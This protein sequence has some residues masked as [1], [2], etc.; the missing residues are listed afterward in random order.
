MRKIN[1]LLLFFDYFIKLIISNLLDKNLFIL[2]NNDNRCSQ[3]SCDGSL[4]HPFENLIQTYTYIQ[5]NIDPNLYNINILIMSNTTTINN[6][7]LSTYLS[8]NSNGIYNIVFSHQKVSILSNFTSSTIVI[9][10]ETNLLAI[11]YINMLVFHNININFNNNQFRQVFFPFISLI[12]NNIFIISNSSLEFSYNLETYYDSFIGNQY[13]MT[14]SLN[15][16]TFNIIDCVFNQNLFQT[17]ILNI[18]SK[19]SSFFIKR[20]IFTNISNY[21]NFYGFNFLGSFNKISIN[22]SKIMNSSQLFYI[23]NSSV[24]LVIFVNITTNVKSL[25]NPS[26]LIYLNYFN[27]ITIEN[28]VLLD[29]SMNSFILINLNFNNSLILNSSQFKNS[30]FQNISSIIHANTSNFINIF[31]IIIENL[32]V[33]SSS[34]IRLEC[35]NLLYMQ[36]TSFLSCSLYSVYGLIYLNNSNIL[37]DNCHFNKILYDNNS[38]IG[39]FFIYGSD[40]ANITNSIFANGN[41]QGIGGIIFANLIKIVYIFNV[42]CYNQT[43]GSAVLFYF[44]SDC[45]VII[46]HLHVNI[47]F[48]SFDLLN[49][50]GNIVLSNSNNFSIKNSE[51][52][53]STSFGFGTILACSDS[54]RINL[55]NLTLYDTKTT[56]IGIIFISSNNIF[57]SE[58]IKII[59]VQGNEMIGLLFLENNAI[60]VYNST[61]FDFTGETEKG[62]VF[63]LI[64][65]NTFHI[66][67]CFLYNIVSFSGSGI[68]LQNTNIMHI[69]NV[70]FD[71]HYNLNKAFYGG[72]L[73]IRTNNTLFINISKFLSSIAPNGA[74]AISIDFN[75]TIYINTCLFYN[76]SQINNTHGQGTIIYLYH[77]NNI[78]I[79]NSSFMSSSGYYGGGV[80]CTIYNIITINSSIFY[81]LTTHNQSSALGGW[82]I[83]KFYVENSSFID[84]TCTYSGGVFY[85][86]VN[87]EGIF[88]NIVCINDFSWNFGGVFAINIL[89]KILIKNSYFSNNTSYSSGGL[90]YIDTN[91]NIFLRNIT[92]IGCISNLF[93]S[94]AFLS[95]GNM[96]YVIDSHIIN[97]SIFLDGGAFY[98]LQTNNFT[99]INTEII[100]LYNINNEAVNGGVFY[101]DTENTLI[102]SNNKIF[103]VSGVISGGIFYLN[104]LNHLICQTS[105]FVKI[106]IYFGGI[107]LYLSENNT[108]EINNIYGNYMNSTNFGSIYLSEN[109]V[110]Y[111]NNSKFINITTK[112]YD[113]GLFYLK[114][115]NIIKFSTSFLLNSYCG[116]YGCFIFSDNFNKILIFTSYIYNIITYA[117]GDFLYISDNNSIDLY[118]ITINIEKTFKKSISNLFYMNKNNKLN[119]S[120]LQIIQLNCNG[121]GCVFLLL[122]ENTLNITN[123]NI[124][125]IHESQE[126]VIISLKS[127]NKL[128]MV[129]GRINLL[130][131]VYNNNNFL[132][133]TYMNEISSINMKFNILKI[134]SMYTSEQDN[135]FYIKNEEMSF[136]NEIDYYFM[137]N[138]LQNYSIKLIGVKF[139]LF[140]NTFVFRII[141]GNFTINHCYFLVKNDNIFIFIFSGESMISIKNSVFINQ[142]NHLFQIID[143]S[144]SKITFLN[145]FFFNQ[146]SKSLDNNGFKIFSNSRIIIK[147]NILI[148]SLNLESFFKINL[149]SNA[150]SMNFIAQKNVFQFHEAVNG[151][152]FHIIANFNNEVKITRNIF[153]YN[154]ASLGGDIFINSSNI[155]ISNNTFYKSKA[156]FHVNPYTKGGA[157]YIAD[158][159]NLFNFSLF[160]NVF[161]GLEAEIGSSIYIDSIDY[162]I[163]L[164]NNSFITNK[165]FIYGSPF[166]SKASKFVF[167]TNIFFDDFNQD[168]FWFENIVSGEIYYNCL[169]KIFP[170]DKF[171]NLML[172]TD[173][174]INLTISQLYSIPANLN[175]TFNYQIIDGSFCFTGPFTR[176]QQILAAL[177]KYTI[178]FGVK[179]V[180]VFLRFRNCDLGEY[181]T[182]SNECVRCEPGTFSFMMNFSNSFI[183]QGCKDADPFTC[184]GGDFLAPKDDFWRFDKYSKNFIKCPKNGI[185][186]QS[187]TSDAKYT[188]QC[189]KGYYGPLCN[190]CENEYG[191]TDK[192]T[193]TLCNQT[194]WYYFLLINAKILFKSCYFLYS[195]YVGFKMIIE[196]TLGNLSKKNII[197]LS[198]LK[199]LIIHFQ[200]ISFIP[201]IPLKLSNV[202]QTGISIVLGFFP[203][204]SDVFFF[205]CY[206]KSKKISFPLTY[207]LLVICPVYILII[208]GISLILIYYS[209]PYKKLKKNNNLINFKDLMKTVFYVI[210]FLSFVDISQVYLEMLQCVNVG[211]DDRK[212]MRLFNNLNIDCSDYSHLY[213]VFGLSIPILF[214]M[215]EAVFL[216]LIKI[217]TSLKNKELAKK[218]Q[219]KFKYGYFYYPY[220]KH[221]F[222]WD[223]ISLARRIFTL[224]IFLYFYDRLIQKNMFPL[225]LIYI[226]LAISFALVFKFKP[227]K[228]KY[229][230]LNKMEVLSMAVLSINYLIVNFY[231]SYFFYKLDIQSNQN[232]FTSLTVISLIILNGVFLLYW[233]KCYYKYYFKKTMIRL[234]QNI[235]SKKYIDEYPNLIREYLKGNKYICSYEILPKKRKK[236]TSE[237]NYKLY[238][239]LS[240]LTKY[241]AF[242]NYNKTS[243]NMINYVIKGIKLKKYMKLGFKDYKT[244]LKNKPVNKIY[245]FFN[246]TRPFNFNLTTDSSLKLNY[247]EYLINYTII[248]TIKEEVLIESYGLYNHGSKNILFIS[249]L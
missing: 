197:A 151:S 183:C 50:G 232:N 213:W 210:I 163:N 196:I 58:N 36:Y 207:F 247:L 101:C 214:M 237:I 20:T 162:N 22:S 192:T 51:I 175:N 206:F 29:S 134:H 8:Q 241:V 32:T 35:Y 81:N 108:A 159:G 165:A 234:F 39:V 1:I 83:N 37:A 87:N 15:N 72:I 143:L 105:E 182:E 86:D 12:S 82:T 218:P 85:I 45:N 56:Q 202:F 111:V 222:F 131:Y 118:N 112:N 77:N 6:S 144:S 65:T 42:F 223:F 64:T 204:I 80:F 63:N 216:L 221:L 211:D 113:G 224:F 226:V 203:E 158:P 41:G 91:N 121:E 150:K 166:A 181:L 3:I 122:N 240:N 27:D 74:A 28:I 212:I 73:S 229:H 96:M 190:I 98:L 69:I 95:E 123:F 208:Y 217:T 24:F 164:S 78:F 49:I 193:C 140:I 225:L 243:K 125:N 127:N 233:T 174:I 100:N 67:S 5:S 25:S 248:I 14:S 44:N 31:K 157:I 23:A 84:N 149:I 99:I 231:C 238:D 156:L 179:T 236:A 199:L 132:L 136:S 4:D 117:T 145:N 176:N 46:D 114:S 129:S 230:I 142:K 94:F 30:Y 55:S 195:I 52:L 147:R 161:T 194:N 60:F 104:S 92:A 249:L 61:F 189:E 71:T 177:F 137:S 160:N 88:T 62:G 79:T 17:G 186:F 19:N 126:Y 170:V 168:T 68:F 16:V 109:N 59:R 148:K 155:F 48:S 235:F 220:K 128:S 115:S 152:V 180:N 133:A 171:G 76:L 219:T 40:F 178:S 120:Y 116:G 135:S 228:E 106:S 97:T 187:N 200:I 21:K 184:N 173:E 53:N 34:L 110:C 227:Y 10:I 139:G 11:S 172:K 138:G 26:N 185:C 13:L 9:Y 102:F 191:K 169:F 93:G 201:Q 244:L 188:G 57:I 66:Q 33:I 153:K 209:K 107:F 146:R 245:D 215:A 242:S 89:N 43:F 119:I 167:F 18:N 90:I 124:S 47:T 130:F 154:K 239:E 75:N 103:N 2:D 54:N 70:T 7:M 38:L 205:E 141:S 198:L 246:F